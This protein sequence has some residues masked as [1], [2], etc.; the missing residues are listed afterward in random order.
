MMARTQRGLAVGLA[1][2]LIALFTV[3]AAV[4]ASLG[5]PY[6]VPIAEG[7]DNGMPW[8]I[9]VFH[10]ASSRCIASV[11]GTGVNARESEGCEVEQEEALWG[12]GHYIATG[13]ARHGEGVLMF[14]VLPRAKRLRVLVGGQWHQGVVE[15]L[16]AE[17]KK[18]ARFDHGVGDI[19]IPLDRNACVRRIVAVGGAGEILERSPRTVCG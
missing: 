5:P 19:L 7:V 11:V 9:S 13:R 6:Q 10:K 4:D 16:D 1:V 17:E 15:V 18:Q 8:S 14:F 12:L 2:V 3:P